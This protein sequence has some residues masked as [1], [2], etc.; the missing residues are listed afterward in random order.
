M[1]RRKCVLIMKVVFSLVI[2]VCIL[3]FWTCGAEKEIRYTPDYPK[4]DLTPYFEKEELTAQEYT[5][6]FQQTGMSQIGVDS[7]RQMGRNEDL[8]ALQKRFFG[9]TKVDCECNFPMFKEELQR[10]DRESGAEGKEFIPVLEEGDILITFNS[11]FLGW[12]NGHAAIVIDAE[13]RLTLEALTLGQDSDILSVNAW[14][15]RPSFVV[16]RVSGATQEKRREVAEYAKENL[17]GIPYQLTAGFWKGDL[18]GTHCSHLIWYAYHHFGYDLDGDGGWIVTPKD[19]RES[20][21][22]DVIQVYGI[23]P[24]ESFIEH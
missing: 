3:F 2:S 4:V 12:R 19:I 9:E 15:E 23:N 21:L 18:Y 5:V 7:L 17:L 14:L 10:T 6:L 1:K 8:L 11:H 24:E 20:P 22:V 13:N 16:L